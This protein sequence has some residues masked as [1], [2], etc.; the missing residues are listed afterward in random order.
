MC[1][2]FKLTLDSLSFTVKYQRD[3]Y[4]AYLEDPILGQHSMTDEKVKMLSELGF[5]WIQEDKQKFIEG[6]I[7]SI[8]TGKRGRPRKVKVEEVQADDDDD[9][10]KS[11]AI[12]Q[13]WMEM[14]EKLK[15]HVEQHGTTDIPKDTE[16]EELL[17]LRNWCS[18]QKSRYSG[19]Q[20]GGSGKGMTSQKIDML[21]S[22]GFN[23][24]PKW[25]VMFSKLLTYKE[26]NGHTRV[27]QQDDPA[28]AKWVSSQSEILGRH[29]QGKGTRLSEEQVMK[30]M[31]LGLQGGRRSIEVQELDS[32][33]DAKWNE[34]YL[35]LVAYKVSVFV[36]SRDASSSMSILTT[37]PFVLYLQVENG[38]ANPPTSACTDLSNWVAAQRR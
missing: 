29:L 23:F 2:Q 1:L 10:E 17:A 33:R 5:T 36:C 32:N 3:Q 14:Y 6:G 27:T 38:H 11:P 19:M 4:K 15:A 9:D 24:P 12:R 13:K 28:L 31:G 25:D 21:K 18:A 7:A 30:L 20:K 8:K 22:I 34:M 26:E 37:S 35:K 16:D